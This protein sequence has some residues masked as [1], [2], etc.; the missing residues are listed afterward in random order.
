MHSGAVVII[1]ELS[2][3]LPQMAFPERNHEIETLTPQGAH[4]PLAVA[5]CKWRTQRRVRITLTPS[6][7]IWLS[8]SREK[9]LSFIV[10]QVS[11]TGLPATVRAAAAESIPPSDAR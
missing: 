4:Q 6:S 8:N 3:D 10:D 5:V 9:M 7:A 11:V 1:A 2:F